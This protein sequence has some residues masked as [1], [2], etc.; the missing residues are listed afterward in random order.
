[1]KTTLAARNQSHAIELA[2]KAKELTDCKAV[3]TSE[4]ELRKK[5]DANCSRLRFQ[6]SAVEEQLIAARAKLMETEA[7]VQQL[8]QHTD[9]GLL[10]RVE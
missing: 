8:E 9:A 3:Q 7:T 5:L 1:M 4:L 10:T 6:L 2:L